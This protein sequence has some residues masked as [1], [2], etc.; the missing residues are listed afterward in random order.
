MWIVLAVFGGLFVALFVIVG[1]ANGIGHSNVPSGD[2]AVVEDAPG[3][4]ITAADFQRSLKQAAARQGVQKVP[5]PSSPQYPSLRDAAMSDALLTRWVRGEADERGIAVS[6]T[7]ISAQLQQIQKQ[8]FGGRKQFQRFLKQAGFTQQDARD[9]VELQ[10]LSN[11]IQKAVL[12]QSTSVSES[13]IQDFYDANRSQF[14]QPETRD[15]REIVNK[16]QAKVAQ[17]KAQLEKDHSAAGWK[18]V[19]P[20]DSTD[21]A[22]NSN[23]GLR[24]GVMKGQSEPALDQ[25]IFS[26][27]QGQLVGPFKGQ[28]GYYLIEVVK[29]TPAQTTPLSSVSAQIKQ[30]LS[31]G[32]QQQ[33]AQSFQQDFIDKWTSR[34]FCGKSYVMDR[35]ANFTP[36]DA[37]NGD[38]SGE[39]GDLGKTGCAAFV[40]STAPVAPGNATVFPGQTTQGLPQGPAQAGAAPAAQPGV[41]GPSGAP[42]LPPGAAP[43]PQTAPP[44]GA[45]PQTA[46]PQGAPPGTTP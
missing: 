40:V 30:Q 7:E 45:P 15:V 32:A 39:S 24:S 11:E 1:V 12:P 4:T 22:T 37:C 20:K 29:I 41:I 31:Q 42:Q 6:D 14:Q 38:D 46:P 25:Q 33:A 23:G 9:R 44:Q 2:V 5:P 17:A 36:Q 35:C 26:A 3:G 10:L 34:S 21:Q 43:T 16:D 27:P 13:Q 19:A 18:K 28:A 8:Q